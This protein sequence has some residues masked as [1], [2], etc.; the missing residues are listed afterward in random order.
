MTETWFKAKDNGWKK[1]AILNRDQLKLFTSDR[2]KGRVGGITLI[3]KNHYQVKCIANHNSNLK[4]FE[5]T[6]WRITAKNT[7][8]TLHG[9]YHPPYS[10][11]NK[12]TN[13]MFIDEFTEFATR[14]IPE[15][16]NNI[17]IGDFNLHVSDNESNDSAIFNDTIE[18]IGLLQH[19]GKETHKSGNTLD[20]IISEI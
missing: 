20:L 1:T 6:T 10:L 5:C 11:N 2:P 14:I 19:V 12:I 16:N 8:I 4:T 7:S 17:F 18:A 15:H 9:L 13:A 3:T